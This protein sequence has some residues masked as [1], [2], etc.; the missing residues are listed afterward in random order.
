MGAQKRGRHNN[1]VQVGKLDSRPGEATAGDGRQHHSGTPNH[2][3]VS[4]T[5]YDVRCTIRRRRRDARLIVRPPLS[6]RT[7]KLTNHFN[8][9]KTFCEHSNDILDPLNFPDFIT[10]V[11]TCLQ[12]GIAAPRVMP[13]DVLEVFNIME[14]AVVDVILEMCISIQIKYSPCTS[15]YTFQ[16]NIYT[17]FCLFRY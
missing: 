2:V 1:G 10:F 15:T 7:S 11:V 6:H 3:T 5:T 12:F 8:T 4:P 17:F 13:T 14:A 9:S 16:N